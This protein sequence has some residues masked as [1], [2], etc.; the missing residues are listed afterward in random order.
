M[1]KDKIINIGIGFATGRKNF[2][3]VLK[4]NVYA[5]KESGITEKENIRLNLFVAY[6]LKYSNTKSTDYTNVSKDVLSLVD[7]TYFIG[8]A[9]VKTEIDYL[10]SEN[11]I[12]NEEAHLFFGSGY[13]AKRNAVL[14][15]AMK[16]NIDYLLF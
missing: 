4:T 7:D 11:V 1:K 3:K 15:T 10:I 13:A 6:D 5:W 12:N 2:Q 16:N 8:G 9:T 14:Y